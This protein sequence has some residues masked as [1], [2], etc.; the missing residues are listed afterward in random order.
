LGPNTKLTSGDVSVAE[1]EKTWMTNFG[2]GRRLPPELMARIAETVAKRGQATA[3][4]LMAELD[5]ASAHTPETW[6]VS[7]AYLVKFDV[8]RIKR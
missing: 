4:E 2:S 7:L 3:G 5:P 1:L 8:L 6:A